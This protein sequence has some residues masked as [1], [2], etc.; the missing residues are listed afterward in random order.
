LFVTEITEDLH[1]MLRL[2]TS[3]RKIRLNFGGYWMNDE[4]MEYIGKAF[5]ALSLIESITLNFSWHEKI[6]DV[7]AKKLAESLKK[8]KSLRKF[9]ARFRGRTGINRAGQDSLQEAL[10]CL[11]CLE[12]SKIRL[13]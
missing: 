9:K 8:L 10:D 11:P 5:E 12:K 3:L 13:Y 2:L 7:G 1:Q 6:T 4:G